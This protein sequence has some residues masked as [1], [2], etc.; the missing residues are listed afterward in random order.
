M[1]AL[2]G[3]LGTTLGVAIKVFSIN[4]SLFSVVLV[5]QAIGSVAQVFVLC[6]PS[7]IAAVWFPPNEVI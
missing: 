4:P 7:K 5:G 3:G 6:L 1:A 2:I